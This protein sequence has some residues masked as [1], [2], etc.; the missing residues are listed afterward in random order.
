MR[1][2]PDL[3]WWRYRNA[4]MALR[5]RGC[6][7]FAEGLAHRIIRAYFAR[8]REIPST[9]T[10]LGYLCG[11][12]EDEVAAVRPE[13]EWVLDMTGPSVRIPWLDEDVERQ[14]ERSNKARTAAQAR[15]GGR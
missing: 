13:L 15:W 2:G 7:V 5:L 11:V 14:V 4:D 3:F 12:T 8:E 9:N 10:V 1:N 6:S